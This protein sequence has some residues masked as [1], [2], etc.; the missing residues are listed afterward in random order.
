MS[1]TTTTPFLTT[2]T[3]RT[4]WAIRTILLL[5]IHLPFLLVA[6]FSFRSLRPHPRYTLRQSLAHHL[7]RTWFEFAAAVEFPFPQD[8][9]RAG[10]EGGRWVTVFPTSAKEEEGS[11]FYRRS[12]LLD[13]DVKPATTG[14]TWYPR[15]YYSGEK[16]GEV[17][18]LH[19]HGGGFVLSDARDAN[20]AA[21][22]ETLVRATGGVVF[23]VEYRLSSSPGNRF[24]AALQ[25]AVSA[26]LYLILEL[27]VSPSRIVLS[28]DSAGGNLA[29]GLLRYIGENADLF[30]PPLTGPT[31]GGRG[32]GGSPCATLLWSPW[33]DLTVQPH[34]YA[35]HPNSKTDYVPASFLAWAQRAYLPHRRL[36]LSHPYI[37]PSHHPFA[38]PTP[39]WIAVGSCEVL[40]DQGVKFAEDM[41]GVVA[42]GKGKGK[43]NGRVEVCELKDVGHDTFLTA[44]LT[45]RRDRAE[46]GAAGAARFL[47][48]VRQE[49]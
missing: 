45:G 24:P 5:T 43:G 29:I 38:T 42:S 1:S 37:S 49:E 17:V 36:P 30:D 33:L 34:E 28:G 4:F 25:D 15:K 46:E 22:A 12:P 31:G 7:L 2:K 32:H 16:E 27:G 26:Y 9:L 48:G 47:R 21:P 41:R 40:R 10:K 44:H 23:F 11:E 14:G 18:I 6:Y 13:A 8:V 20:C 35:S 3:G 19:F 39:I